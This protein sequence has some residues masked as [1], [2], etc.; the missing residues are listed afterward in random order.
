MPFGKREKHVSIFWPP[1]KIKSL[2]R[3]YD[4]TQGVFCTRLGVSPDALQFWEQGRGSPSR[5]IELLLDRLEEDAE[6]SQI[7]PLPSNGEVIGNGHAAA[8]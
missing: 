2:R 1:E 8:S 4:E 3:R 5:P 7:R 6:A